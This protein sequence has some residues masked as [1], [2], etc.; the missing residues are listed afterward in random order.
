MIDLKGASPL[1]SGSIYICE[2][3]GRGSGKS[4]SNHYCQEALS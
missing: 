3:T 1:V 4:R 2:Q